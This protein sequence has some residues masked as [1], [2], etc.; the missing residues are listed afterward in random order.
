MFLRLPPI[1]LASN[2]PR[3]QELLRAMGIEFSVTVRPT[4]EF[5]SETDPKAVVRDIVAQKAKAHAHL[6]QASLVICADTVVV[7]GQRILGKPT[8]RAQAGQ[9]LQDLSATS[10]AVLTA[11]SLQFQDRQRV[12]VES[13]MVQFG[14]LDVATIE[15]YIATGSPLDKAG[16]YG[17]QDWIGLVGITAIEGDYYNVMGLPCARL[18]QE[19]KAFLA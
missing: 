5:S 4:P 14:A 9:M 8:D 1:I 3:R 15:H 6:A 18:W 2:S 17:I 19:L 10:H 11:V 12:F 13:T 7:L 16:G